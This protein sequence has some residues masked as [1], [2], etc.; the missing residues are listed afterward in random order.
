MSILALFFLSFALGLTGAMSPGPFLS[1]AIGQAT[2]RGPSAGPLL[3][4][5]HGLIELALMV[6]IVAGLGSLLQTRLFLILISFVGGP[7]LV[8]MGVSALRGL[9]KYAFVADPGAQSTGLHPTVAGVVLSVSNP[10]WFIWWISVAVG[11]ILL[12]KN[13]GFYGLVAFYTGHVS[14][15]LVWFSFI[16]FG[17]HFGGRYIKPTVLKFVLF[18]CNL[19]L[20]FFGLYFLANGFRLL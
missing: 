6:A 12:A 4:L 20:V 13:L 10:F 19:F 18:V 14:A 1:M 16:S 17:V 5:G 7:I 15:D 2:R 9:R 11:Y 3:V 8:L